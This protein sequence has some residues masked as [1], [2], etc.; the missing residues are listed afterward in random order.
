MKITE[1]QLMQIIREERDAIEFDTP[2]EVEAK[3][4]VWEGGENLSD[5][6][7]HSKEAG[8]EAV[9]PEPEVLKITEGQLRNM[10]QSIMQELL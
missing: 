5:D 9:T 8:G 4:D 7:D 6:V 2:E 3:L 10:I 1:R